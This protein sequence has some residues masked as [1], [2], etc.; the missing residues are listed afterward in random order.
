M[1]LTMHFEGAGPQDVTT[2][3]TP[4]P[5]V[6]VSDEE[7]GEEDDDEDGS[8]LIPIPRRVF[9]ANQP[10]GLSILQYLLSFPLTV[11]YKAFDGLYFLLSKLFPR[12]FGYPPAPAVPTKSIVEQFEET[13]GNTGLSLYKQGFSAAFEAARK[14]F[15]YLVVVLE[16][17]TDADEQFN[18][19][20]LTDARVAEFLNN[21]ETVLWLGST[22][23]EGS[24]VAK[25]LRVQTFPTVVLIGAAPKSRTSFG[26]TM[27]V[28]AYIHGETDPA[29]LV[30]ALRE[31]TERHHP[32]RM[33]LVLD[34]QEREAER[35]LRDEQNAAYE[36]SLQ[37]DREREKQRSEESARLEKEAL[38]AQFAAEKA[39]LEAE[40]AQQE[41]ESLQELQKQWKLWRAGQLNSSTAE[42]SNEKTAR[43][44]IRLLSGNRIIHNF[45]SSQTLEDIYAYVECYDFLNDSSLE[46]F[47]LS[48]PENYT[49]EYKFQLASA[50][51]RQVLLADK[52]TLVKDEKSVWPSGALVVEVDELSDEE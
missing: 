36:R 39:A 23:G 52:G 38:E 22:S 10:T 1:A 47:P 43:V 42:P 27:K 25:S 15:K 20:V 7:S 33:A 35:R 5:V 14:D 19:Q 8:E 3:H 17:E 40:K 49:H 41:K 18:R 45:A 2:T 16:S 6:P 11:G 29:M 37:A 46:K 51:P 30:Q 44:A 31:Q 26:V 12:L 4:V 9:N 34:R 32:K 28:L 13:Y 24:A 48:P 21:E 50:M